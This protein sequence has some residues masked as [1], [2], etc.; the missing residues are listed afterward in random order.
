MFDTSTLKAF[1]ESSEIRPNVFIQRPH[2]VSIGKHTRIDW[3]FYL[4]PPA[5]LGDYIHIAPY[6]TVIGGENATFVL[7][8]FTT[9]A[10][11]SR[12]VCASDDHRGEGLVGPTIP[13][14][15]RDHVTI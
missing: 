2:L 5:I 7:E 3:G 1:G 15:F 8:D 12:I 6:V 14:E 13:D 9:I 4:T 10:A 11:G